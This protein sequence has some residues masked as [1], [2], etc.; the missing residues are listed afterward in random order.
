MLKFVKYR[1]FVIKY[2]EISL[3]P[4][5]RYFWYCEK[6]HLRLVI[7]FFQSWHLIRD[8]GNQ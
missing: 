1:F 5:Y 8:N 4:K 2:N 7:A 3:I 6:V